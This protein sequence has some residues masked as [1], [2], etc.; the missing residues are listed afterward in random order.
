[1]N[2][3]VKDVNFVRSKGFKPLRVSNCSKSDRGGIQACD[4][5]FIYIYIYIY[6][7]I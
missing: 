6:I 3:T 4:E 2:V 7:Y 1:M 5:L